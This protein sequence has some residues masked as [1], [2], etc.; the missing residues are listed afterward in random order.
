M[1]DQPLARTNATIR[2]S[3]CRNRDK[4]DILAT[5]LPEKPKGAELYRVR[6]AAAGAGLLRFL[7]NR[8]RDARLLLSNQSE[9]EQARTEA[10]YA[11]AD[12]PALVVAE[13]LPFPSARNDV[14]RAF[15]MNLPPDLRSMHADIARVGTDGLDS[16]LEVFA[17]RLDYDHRLAVLQRRFTDGTLAKKIA[18]L[19]DC[20]AFVENDG[21]A[22]VFLAKR[23]FNRAVGVCGN[24]G[25]C[26]GKR[27]GFLPAENAKTVGKKQ[28]PR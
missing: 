20:V 10:W 18:A 17:S 12:Q 7:K 14:R 26:L 25:W 4:A 3:P 6:T 16:A 27:S 8:G 1:T 11:A 13:P 24:C 9:P 21:C 2:L 28:H 5:R 22:R 15:C 19:G 23:L